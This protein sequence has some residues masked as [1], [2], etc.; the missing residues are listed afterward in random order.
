[1]VS[2]EP[3]TVARVHAEY[4]L[5]EAHEKPTVRNGYD[6]LRS[7]LFGDLCQNA[8]TTL[9]PLTRAFSLGDNVLK[10]NLLI[11]GALLRVAV[12]HLFEGQPLEDAH[13]PLAEP[14][15]DVERDAARRSDDVR[16]PEGTT[17][18]ARVD[19]VDSQVTEPTSQSCCLQ[20]ATSRERAIQ[21]TYF[22]AI[23]VPLCFSVSDRE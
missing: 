11:G 12:V 5:E 1:M 19:G 7:V 21:M 18:I 10:A 8:N 3:P 23:Q 13:V 22:P 16:C 4:V 20:Q 2:L 17:E 6:P 9:Q 14:S 15:I